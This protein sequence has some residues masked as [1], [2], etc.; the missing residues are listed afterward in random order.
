MGQEDKNGDAVDR[1]VFGLVGDENATDSAKIAAGLIVA[2]SLAKRSDPDSPIT[3][4]TLKVGIDK[5]WPAENP[6]QRWENSLL[7]GSKDGVGLI[8]DERL[9]QPTL[10]WTKEHDQEHATGELVLAALCYQAVPG[11][12]VALVDCSTTAG[13]LWPWDPQKDPQLPAIGND[14]AQARIDRL[15]KAGALI[16]AE[17]DRLLPLVKPIKAADI[18][19]AAKHLEKENPTRARKWYHTEPAIDAELR[20]HRYA[21]TP[22][23]KDWDE[24]KAPTLCGKLIAGMED[25]HGFKFGTR[26]KDLGDRRQRIAMTGKIAD[27]ACPFCHRVE[28][29]EG[30]PE[31]Y[32]VPKR[33]QS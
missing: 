1:L 25:Y 31:L 22:D 10:G 26:G 27:H 6:Q 15:K 16:A 2:I 5:L 3:N 13:S 29:E 28:Q 20:I 8:R 9:R 7:H 30:V 23:P 14:T 32:T 33:E 4:E 17:I 19:E 18:R 24:A 21:L 12:K 11:L